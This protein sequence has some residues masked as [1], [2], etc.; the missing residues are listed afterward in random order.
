MNSSTAKIGFVPLFCITS[1]AVGLMNHVLVLP[2]LL[3]VARRDAWLSVLLIVIPFIIWMAV[4]HQI[5]RLTNQQPILVWMQEQYGRA[6]SFALRVLFFFHLFLINVITVNETLTWATGSY[7]PRTPEFALSVTLMLVGCYAAFSGL[8]AIAFTAGILFP[9]V[10]IFGD[11]VMSA[12]LPRKNYALLFPVLE[13]GWRPLVEGAGYVLGGLSELV[14][15]LLL[16]HY[17]KNQLPF[18]KICLLGLFLVLLI[19]GPVTG[20]IAEFGPTEAA[21]LRYPAYEQWRLVK[22]GRYIQHLDFFSIYQ[23]LTGAFVRVAASMFLMLEL[24]A[25]EGSVKKRLIWM[26]SIAA[27]VLILVSLPFSDIQFLY[28]LRAYLLASMAVVLLVLI[29]LLGLANLAR[30]R[31]KPT[32][33]RTQ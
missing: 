2:P 3:G 11:F 28:F 5:M 26:F 30:W 27:A 23:W 15:V 19:F 9:F 32:D 14:M 21:A 18:W 20:A 10:V 22:L 24:A 16:Q 8:R 6:A 13:Y 25:D 33:G 7:L 29:A 4:L 12:N 31:G 1:L 17:L